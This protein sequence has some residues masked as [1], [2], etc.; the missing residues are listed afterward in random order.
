VGVVDSEPTTN[1]VQHA[2]RFASVDMRASPGVAR[3]WPIFCLSQRLRPPHQLDRR[4][5]R[6]PFRSGARPGGMNF[7]DARWR[8]EPE[9][10]E[11]AFLSMNLTKAAMWEP[12]RIEA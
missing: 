3:A 1:D 5:S 12:A 8:C 7:P 11:A 10:G 9:E 4:P 6:G 2:D